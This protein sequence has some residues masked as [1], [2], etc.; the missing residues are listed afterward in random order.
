MLWLICIE[1][2]FNLV[3]LHCPGNI[4]NIQK[5]KNLDGH[6]DGFASSL[7]Q[8]IEYRPLGRN[9]VILFILQDN[10]RGHLKGRIRG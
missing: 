10:S 4:R 8:Y 1:A 2:I 3:I 5:N 7:S 6:F 9:K